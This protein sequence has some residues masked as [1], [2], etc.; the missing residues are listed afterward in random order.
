V[1]KILRFGVVKTGL[2]FENPPAFLTF[3]QS[4]GTGTSRGVQKFGRLSFIRYAAN[5]S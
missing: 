3:S 2:E 5:L 1:N 4:N